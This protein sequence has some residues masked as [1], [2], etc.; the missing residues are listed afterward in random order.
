MNDVIKN[1]NDME[2]VKE[3]MKDFKQSGWMSLICSFIFIFI[4]YVIIKNFE[5]KVIIPFVIV[6]LFA[7]LCLKKF[8]DSLNPKITS[9]YVIPVN[10]KHVKVKSKETDCYVFATING[11]EERIKVRNKYFER[12][13]EGSNALF[14]TLNNSKRLYALPLENT[15]QTM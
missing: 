5:G 7:F 13:T 6:T 15:N 4:D 9:F 10:R 14:F 8:I 11:K 1:V 12:F 3:F 2:I